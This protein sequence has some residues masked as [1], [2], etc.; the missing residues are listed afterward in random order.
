MTSSSTATVP[1]ESGAAPSA[2][3]G[4]GDASPGMLPR[5]LRRRGAT[6]LAV[7]IVFAMGLFGGW[8]VAERVQRPPAVESVDVGFLRDMGDHHDQAVQLALIELANGES[9]L[10]TG[11]ALDVV[12][13][14]RYEIGLMDARLRDWGHG[15]GDLPREAMAWMGHSV[16][17]DQMPGMASSEDIAIFAAARGREADEMFIDLMTDHHLGGLHMAERAWFHAETQQVRDLAERIAKLQQIEIRDL[18]LA[19]EQ[20]ELSP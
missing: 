16:P 20:M 19:R 12:A 15:R 10:L 17:M 2:P 6:A 4:E 8:L 11:F 9:E 7:A 18:Q 13:S 14:Q 1:R 3:R 5:L